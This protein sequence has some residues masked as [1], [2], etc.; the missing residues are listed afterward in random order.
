VLSFKPAGFESWSRGWAGIEVVCLHELVQNL[1]IST[2]VNHII[3][4]G[5][6]EIIR[7]FRC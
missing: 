5:A 4:N 2:S 3:L 1:S 7:R 6:M